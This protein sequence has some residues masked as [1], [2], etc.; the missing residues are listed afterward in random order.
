MQFAPANLIPVSY[1]QPA[2]IPFEQGCATAGQIQAIEHAIGQMEQIEEIVEHHFAPGI[3]MR[4]LTIPKGATIVG[5]RHSDLHG[6][7]VAKGHLLVASEH[8]NREL[9]A[10]DVFVSQPGVKRVGHAL[11]ETVFINVHANPDNER[12]LKK[13]EARYITPEAISFK[14]EVLT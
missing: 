5:K 11:E 12:D 8:G 4:K 10:G 13:L 7:I 9:F 1:V 14:K 2:L 6:C 3:Y